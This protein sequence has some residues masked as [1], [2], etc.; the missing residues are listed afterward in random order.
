MYQPL[1]PRLF[2]VFI[3]TQGKAGNQSVT[4]IKGLIKKLIFFFLTVFIITIAYLGIIQVTGVPFGTSTA[5]KKMNQY[6]QAQY[7]EEYEVAD[8]GY[9]IF[10]M[11]YTGYLYRKD[12]TSSNRQSLSTLTYYVDTKTIEDGS[13]Q[14]EEIEAL[15]A[16]VTEVSHN[17]STGV[18]SYSTKTQAYF[19]AKKYKEKPQPIY[20]IQLYGLTSSIPSSS[21]S[22][23]KDLFAQSAYEIIQSIPEEYNVQQCH[24][25]F[26]DNTGTYEL[27]VDKSFRGM[28]QS[29]IK[30]K[31]SFIT[32]KNNVTQTVSSQAAETSE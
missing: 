18:Q 3:T 23:S 12:D 27:Q 30:S 25:L 28:S 11:S 16:K 31:I 20:S 9:N 7:G 24:M 4:D 26:H 1:T 13:Y 22:Y 29:K 15:T 14:N 5:E 32:S 19:V 17:L 10:E 21:K 8:V 2:V 6:A